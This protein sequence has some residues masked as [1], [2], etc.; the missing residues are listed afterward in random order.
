[1]REALLTGALAGLEAADVPTRTAVL[2]DAACD[3]VHESPGFGRPAAPAV[4]R[5]VL[6]SVGRRRPDRRL[7]VTRALVTVAPGTRSEVD[8]VLR[9]VWA[10]PPTAAECGLLVDALGPALAEFGPLREL[11]TRVFTRLAGSDEDLEAAESVALAARIREVLPPECVAD[12]AVVLAYAA[13]VQAAEPAAAARW[14]DEI[15]AGRASR[16]LAA[17]VFGCAARRLA[18]RTPVFR[19]ALLA[20]AREEARDELIAHWTGG[21]QARAARTELVE[22]AIRLRLLGAGDR[23]L[24]EWAGGQAAGRLAYARLDSYFR[25]HNELRAALKELAAKGRRQRRGG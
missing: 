17:A 18:D 7:E 9:E 20:A 10:Q 19:A 5:R 14:L 12:G 24:E 23:L 13:A 1:V 25:D 4:A 8:A 11:P 2:T 21:K 16:P 3:L 22:V 15:A 6:G